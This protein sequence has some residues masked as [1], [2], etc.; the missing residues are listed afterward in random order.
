MRVSK[1]WQKFHFLGEISV[2]YS[3]TLDLATHLISYKIIYIFPHNFKWRLTSCKLIAL[4]TQCKP[5]SISSG[6]FALNTLRKCEP[7]INDHSHQDV[8]VIVP[9]EPASL[10]L[11]VMP[12]PK[13][14]L[15]MCIWRWGHCS[16]WPASHKAAGVRHTESPRFE[17]MII[18][19]SPPSFCRPPE[20]LYIRQS[21]S[22]LATWSQIPS[23]YTR[24][25]L[26][27]EN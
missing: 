18:C 12:H 7:E 11:A 13:A 6:L 2:W 19:L 4:L 5:I 1:R 9:A 25:L 26:C 8:P 17:V 10:Q 20:G 3:P 14:R 23:L 15:N 21:A 22:S 16:W 27:P 24:H